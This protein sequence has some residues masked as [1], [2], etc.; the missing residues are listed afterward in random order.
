MQDE[1]ANLEEKQKLYALLGAGNESTK[2]ALQ[3]L[4]GNLILKKEIEKEL[5]PVLH[6][7]NKKTLNSLPNFLKNIQNNF[8]K[9]FR[10][11]KE[12]VWFASP[13]IS[14][15]LSI[16]IHSLGLGLC[17]L[18]TI[19]P[20]IGILSNLT[21]LNLG[22]NLLTQLPESIGQ[23][24]RLERLILSRNQLKELPEWIGELTALNW[25]LLDKNEL[26]EIPNSIKHLSN[27]KWLS[28]KG[29]NLDASTIKK[30][31]VILPKCNIDW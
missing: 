28:L 1:L 6:T 16:H 13:F 21:Q 11:E 27:L 30:L 18:T 17:K 14:H 8:L 24:S 5:L 22:N 10:E 9:V 26:T 15:Q 29:N 19:T 31:K 3:V 20:N 23:L 2:V 12:S 25:L 7:V 4:K